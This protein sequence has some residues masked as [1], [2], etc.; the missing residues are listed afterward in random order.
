M[1]STY[2]E[3]M[4][5]IGIDIN[6]YTYTR[7][8][9]L[10]KTAND[11]RE[12]YP[13]ISDGYMGSIKDEYQ[14]TGNIHDYMCYIVENADNVNEN[15]EYY[16]CFNDELITDDIKLCHDNMSS[17]HVDVMHELKALNQTTG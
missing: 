11:I 8:N 3:Q 6:C 16:R 2:K 9:E 4:K 7:T 10:Y 14:Q 5:Q 15:A 13:N 17:K 12:Y 1:T